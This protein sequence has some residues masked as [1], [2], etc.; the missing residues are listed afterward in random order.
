MIASLDVE[1]KPQVIDTN[2]KGGDDL[3]SA[4]MVQRCPRNKNKGNNNLLFNKPGNTTTFKKKM[5]KLSYTAL[6]VESRPPIPRNAQ[7]VQ[8]I[9][10]TW[11]I[12]SLTL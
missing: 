7:D 3:P 12:R 11:V 8:T 2:D 10:G 6:S 5:N 1:E 4:Y 9:E